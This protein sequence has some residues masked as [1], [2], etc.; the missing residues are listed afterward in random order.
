V[1]LD[2]EEYAFMLRAHLIKE[3]V[4]KHIDLVTLF[5]KT[6]PSRNTERY[7]NEEKRK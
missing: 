4:Q 2:A 7:S 1:C 6:P 5:L 3:Y